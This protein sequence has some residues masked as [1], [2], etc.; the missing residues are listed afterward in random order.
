MDTYDRVV[1]IV[2]PKKEKLAEAEGALA[3]QM[4]KLNA[5]RSELQAVSDQ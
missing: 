2:K 4:E 3:I 1:K 5:K